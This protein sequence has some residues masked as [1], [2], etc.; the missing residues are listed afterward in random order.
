M[1]EASSEQRNA[2]GRLA[3][4]IG[5]NRYGRRR[6]LLLEEPQSVRMGIPTAAARAR[7]RC[8]PGQMAIDADCHIGA[9][10]RGHLAGQGR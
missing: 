4:S 5:F 10:L 3:M 1:K 7:S 2:I 6:I 8:W 9:I